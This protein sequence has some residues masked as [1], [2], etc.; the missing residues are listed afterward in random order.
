MSS[1]SLRDLEHNR[2]AHDQQVK[3]MLAQDISAH[4]AAVDKSQKAPDCRNI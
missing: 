1:D 3:P 4:A 2:S